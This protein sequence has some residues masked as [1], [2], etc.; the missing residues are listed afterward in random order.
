VGRQENSE[1]LEALLNGI[2][3]LDFRHSNPMWRYYELDSEERARLVPGLTDYLPDD[4]GNR[5]IGGTDE[6]DRMRFGAKHNDIYPI[7]GDM[8]RWKLELPNRHAEQKAMA[9]L[10]DELVIDV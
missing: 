9:K 3:A 6:D 4:D 7:L 5:D 10:L 1:H 8:I 2:G